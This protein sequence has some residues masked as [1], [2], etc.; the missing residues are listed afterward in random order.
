MVGILKKKVIDIIVGRPNLS[1]FQ[2]VSYI[3]SLETS[4]INH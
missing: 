1:N 3:T 4:A 2:N